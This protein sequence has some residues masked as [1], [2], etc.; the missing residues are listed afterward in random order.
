MRDNI[1]AEMFEWS[2]EL[3]ARYPDSGTMKKVIVN[4][5]IQE[6]GCDIL[7]P[8]ENGGIGGSDKESVNS[9]PVSLYFW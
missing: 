4:Y 8:G 9:R 7:D 5:D 3:S 2:G 6:N 1:E